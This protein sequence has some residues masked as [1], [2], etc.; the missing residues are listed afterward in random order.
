MSEENDKTDNSTQPPDREPIT[1]AHRQIAASELYEGREDRRRRFYGRRESDKRKELNKKWLYV[2][3]F[4]I[5]VAAFAAQ[6]ISYVQR[7]NIKQNQENIANIVVATNVWGCM[8]VGS[9]SRSQLE[10]FLARWGDI[11]D[12]ELTPDCKVIKL[13]TQQRAR[14]ALEAEP[15]L[16][17]QIP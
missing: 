16:N 4:I 3:V 2:A 8:I 7:T 13:K 11:K 14:R 9:T 10:G 5:G 6:Y 12:S 17:G 1:D 15:I